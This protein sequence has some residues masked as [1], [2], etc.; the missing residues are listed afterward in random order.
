M[1]MVEFTRDHGVRIAINVDKIHVV[2][3]P[4]SGEYTY[5]Y[6]GED[7]ERYWAVKESYEEVIAMITKK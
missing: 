6:V 5:I 7:D 3:L 2:M 1:R 4:V